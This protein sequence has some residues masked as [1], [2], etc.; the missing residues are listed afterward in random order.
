MIHRNITLEAHLI[1]DLLDITRI[2]HG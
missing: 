1:D 2:E